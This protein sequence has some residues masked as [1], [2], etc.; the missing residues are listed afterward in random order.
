MWLWAAIALARDL[1]LKVHDMKGVVSGELTVELGEPGKEPVRF[2]V[3]DDGTAPDAVAG[4]KMY[5]ARVEGLS[6]DHGA[7]VVRAGERTWQG[8][9]RFETPNDPVLLIGLEENGFAAASTREVMFVPQDRM[10]PGAPG[11]PG[12]S[13]SASG[14]APGGG[15]GAPPDGG[16]EAAGAVATRKAPSRIGAPDGMWLGWGIAALVVAGLGAIAWAGAGRT[17]RIP[18]LAGG[19]PVTTA[20][21]GPFVPGPG[22]DV[23]VGPPAG[24]AG[25]SAAA[26]GEGRWR[27]EEIALAALCVR[28][29]ARVVVTD[30]TCVEAE[31]NAYEALAA[32]LVGV[33]DLLWVEAGVAPAR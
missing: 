14:G 8:G 29:V 32:A 3:R 2:V 21:R 13:A 4:D 6:V 33:A 19:T 16:G 23:F 11:T 30:P 26:L 27:P 17:P 1:D 25:A 10:S 5:T 7:V 28:G 9:F 22:R 24:D 18:P 31:G 15:S 20:A 12:G